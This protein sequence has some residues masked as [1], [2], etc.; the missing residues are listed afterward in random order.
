MTALV[1][2]SRLLDGSHVV[3]LKFAD[4]RV[5][6]VVGVRR[7]DVWKNADYWRRWSALERLRVKIKRRPSD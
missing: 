4:G 1:K 5:G 6:R 2:F 7:E 3:T